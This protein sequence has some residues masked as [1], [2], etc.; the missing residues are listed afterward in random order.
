[1]WKRYSELMRDWLARSATAV[2]KGKLACDFPSIIVVATDQ[3]QSC[4]HYWAPK[5]PPW[6]ELL[7]I[8][9]AVL[10]C[11]RTLLQC[12]A[13][14]SSVGVYDA[15]RQPLLHKW[16]V[17]KHCFNKDKLLCGRCCH[18]QWSRQM[19]QKRFV[20]VISAK[21][22]SGL[23]SWSVFCA[24]WPKLRWKVSRSLCTRS[25]VGFF[26][27]DFCSLFI[28]LRIAHHRKGLDESCRCSH[29]RLFILCCHF[30]VEVWVWYL[31]GFL[32]DLP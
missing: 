7:E 28:G 8:L 11:F 19:F 5:H 30:L 24:L 4:A 25:C 16:V 1:M 26:L 15:E 22:I 13:L 29:A 10:V 18:P 14:F 20:I 21:T 31:V 12:E 17:L 3:T 32:G 9:V 6:A 2:L 27:I 23:C